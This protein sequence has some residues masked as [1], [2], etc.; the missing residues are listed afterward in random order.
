MSSTSVPKSL[1]VVRDSGRG[2]LRV[3]SRLVL[4][5]CC[6]TLCGVAVCLLALE[7]VLSVAQFNTKS[8]TRI[9][10]GQGFT[11]LPGAYYRH[12]KEGFSEGRFNSHGFR[13]YERSYEK[14]KGTYRILVLGDSYAEGMQVALERTFPALLEKRLNEA[15][16]G[17]VRFEVLNL[18][19]S[20]FGTADEYM[21]YLDFGVKYTPDLVLLAFLTG[22]DIRNNS[23]ILNRDAIGFYF[24]YDRE[25][26]LQLDRSVIQDY[27]QSLTAP[28]RLL[29]YLAQRSYVVSLASERYY[30]FRDQLNERH[31][32]QLVAPA[33]QA[34]NELDE[35]SD[36][37]VYRPDMSAR[38][39]KALAITEGLLLRFRDDAERHRSRFLL[40]TLSNAEQIDPAVQRSIAA[41]YAVKLDFDQPD[42]ILENFA[43]EHDISCLQLLPVFRD[44]YRRTGERLHGF[45]PVQ[46]GHWNEAGHRRAAET[47]FDFLRRTGVVLLGRRVE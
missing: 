35:L 40:V 27:E 38:W 11:Y 16:R 21:R 8:N 26:K 39:Q 22:N 23:R 46:G 13:D 6:A 4:L 37:N 44:H 7:A 18:G 45:G 2:R 34:P 29:Q 15:A 5:A 3:P 41:R 20:G 42:R 19:Q 17:S 43:T 25:G 1:P 10:P 28:K 36:L 12:M 31:F 32:E 30:L 9:V 24:D 47:I 14:H 33:S